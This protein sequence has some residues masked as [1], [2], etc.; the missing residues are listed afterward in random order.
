ML[1]VDES[2]IKLVSLGQKVQLMMDEFA[3]ERFEGEVV[4]VSQDS[5]SELPR[6]LSI[7]NGGKVA[8]EPGRD[9]RESPL[10]TSYEVSVSINSENR[11]LLTGFRGSAK[12]QVSSLPLGQQLVRYVQTVINFR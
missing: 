9:G 10:L 6:E 8:V 3:G 12:I 11:E 2:D 1:V 4:N 5:L 7:T